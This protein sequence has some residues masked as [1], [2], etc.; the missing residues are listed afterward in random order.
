MKRKNIKESIKE[1]FFQY[2]TLRLRVREAE[3]ELHLPLPSIIRYFKELEKENILK[4]EKI[5][6]IHTFAADRTSHIFLLE[7]RLFNI[8]QMFDSGIIEYL[9]REYSNP[10]IVLFGSYGRGEDVES[11]DIDLYI[12]TPSKR[13]IKLDKFEKILKRKI[14][15]FAHKNIKEISNPHLANNIINGITL[16]GFVEAFT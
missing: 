13:D 1:Y 9:I 6:N 5:S 7:K 12:Q 4:K 8:K 15:I 14:Q 3:R 2:P 11:S 10:T 16:H